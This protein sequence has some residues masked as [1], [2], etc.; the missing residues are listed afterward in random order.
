MSGGLDGESTAVGVGQVA[1]SS[2]HF[3]ISNEMFSS[4]LDWGSSPLGRLKGQTVCAVRSAWQ[5]RHTCIVFRIASQIQSEVFPAF[6]NLKSF[7]VQSSVQAKRCIRCDALGGVLRILV[8]GGVV[9]VQYA[10]YDLVCDF[11]YLC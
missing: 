5:W 11:P 3:G 8:S 9:G 6:L 1:Y 7:E 2:F 4:A 10:K